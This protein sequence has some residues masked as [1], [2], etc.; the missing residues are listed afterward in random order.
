MKKKVDI[1]S[2]DN[3]PVSNQIQNENIPVDKRFA[4]VKPIE[5]KDGILIRNGRVYKKLD[6][7]YGMYADNGAVFKL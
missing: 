5:K 1:I 7:N 2:L 3:K 6:S 4:K